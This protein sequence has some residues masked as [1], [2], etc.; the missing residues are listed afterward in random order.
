M[1]AKFQVGDR[2]KYT[3]YTPMIL[4]GEC[5]TVASILHEGTQYK[6]LFDRVQHADSICHHSHLASVALGVCPKKEEVPFGGKDDS[7]KINP[8]L[9]TAGC[10]NAL[11]GVVAVLHGGAKKYS[12]HSWKHVEAG[13]ERYLAAAARHQ[14]EIDLHGVFTK[15]PDFGLLHLDHLICD[16]LF[17]RELIDK[18]YRAKQT[19]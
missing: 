4:Q 3:G 15:N 5:G 18:E 9:L 1:S 19:V 17:V 2:V 11:A 12:A 8:R 14:A 10:P 16:L 7:N 13:V 6:V